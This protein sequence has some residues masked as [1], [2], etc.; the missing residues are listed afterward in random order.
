VSSARAVAAAVGLAAALVA[1]GCAARPAPVAPPGSFALPWEVPAALAGQQTLFRAHYRGPRGD[2]G[3]R[4]VLRLV[5]PSRYELAASD[6]LGRQLWT[7]AADGEQALFLDHRAARACRL[8]GEV[9]LPDLGLP[10]LPL[11]GVPALLLGRLPVTPAGP[12]APGAFRDADG[13][14][15]TF[16]L[17]ES[18][19]VSWTLWDGDQ[20]SLFWSRQ[21]GGAVLSAR[22]EGAQLRW[23]TSQREPLAAPPAPP[24]VP[25]GFAEGSC[26]E[27]RLP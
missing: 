25:A 10:R 4:L 1:L 16:T 23:Q 18:D 5:D 2:G 7:L 17:R 21:G 24:R 22:R 12:P 19:P 20:A 15:W 11:A 9:Q 27:P 6:A 8:A 14:R 3:F 13:R 26:D